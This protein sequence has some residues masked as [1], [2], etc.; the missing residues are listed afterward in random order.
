MKLIIGI[1]MLNDFTKL[2]TFATVIKE[3]SFSKVFMCGRAKNH[4]LA[5]IF[6]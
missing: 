1:Y 2:E 6:L 4:T 3:K 5:L